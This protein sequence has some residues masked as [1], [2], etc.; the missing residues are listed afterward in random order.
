M[1]RRELT[2]MENYW[3][4]TNRA[5]WSRRKLLTV[6][7]QGAIGLGALALIGCSSG[8][9][10]AG[11]PPAGA[12]AAG[13]SPAAAVQPKRGGTIKAVYNYDTP[14]MDIHSAASAGH[15]AG[16]GNPDACVV[17]VDPARSSGGDGHCRVLVQSAR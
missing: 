13:S 14:T 3:Q 11:S 8:A 9:K 17:L 5:R 12:P 16:V 2:A 10:P 4:M 6:G 1:I 15:G 7:G